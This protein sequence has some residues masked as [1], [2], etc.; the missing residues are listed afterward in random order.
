MLVTK[1]FLVAIDLHY[2][3]KN[4]LKVYGSQSATEKEMHTN[5]EKLEE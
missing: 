1:Q 4:T 5:S 2:M 3:E